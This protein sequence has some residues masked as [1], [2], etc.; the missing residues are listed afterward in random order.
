MAKEQPNDVIT[1]MR[2]GEA[3]EKQGASDKAAAAFEQALKLNPRLASAVT[4]L[5]QLYAGPLQNKEKAL[6]YAKKARELTPN[7]P[8]VTSILGKIAYQSG[9]VTWSYSLLQ[10][11]A[12]QR[13]N[14]PSILH[15]LAWAAYGLGKVNEARDAMQKVL[16]NNAD[17]SQ[18]ADAKKFLALTKLS[19]NPKE[20]MGSEAELQ[21]E[22]NSD[23][24]YLPALMAQAA[25]DKQRGQIKPATEIYNGILRRWPDFAPAQK[26]FATLYAHDPSATATAYDLAAK[27][28]Q[29]LPDDAELAELLGQLSYEKKE[30]QRAIQL[31]QESARA[32]SLNANSLFYLGMS[33]LQVRQKTEAQGVLNQALLAG[34]QEPLAS[35]AR[36]ALADIGRE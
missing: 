11:A 13:E 2:L 15:N 18:A 25:L 4:K 1:Q 3:Y 20:L 36:R 29:A 31:L 12:R 26:G 10:E 28:R 9:N 6:A 7:D 22:L 35:E 17:S 21:K 30:Y 19:E 14:D 5:A 8:Q 32:K 23:P 24:E 16:T 34:L 27:A 33:E